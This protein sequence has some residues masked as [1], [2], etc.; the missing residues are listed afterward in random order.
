WFE[1][2]R[3]R[4][5]EQNYCPYVASKTQ[6]YLEIEDR[7]RREERPHRPHRQRT[8]SRKNRSVRTLPP[9][10][11][12]FHGCLRYRFF[13]FES[14]VRPVRLRQRSIYIWENPKYSIKPRNFENQAQGFL[15]ATQEKLATIRLNLLHG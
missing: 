5:F 7:R 14:A 1:S 6:D 9:K 8:T 15:Q 11:G 10:F 3:A 13:C 2:S 12:D 4:Q